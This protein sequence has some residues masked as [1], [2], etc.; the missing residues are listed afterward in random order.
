L[1]KNE[2]DLQ[3]SVNQRVLGSSLRGGATF[4]KAIQEIEWFFVFNTF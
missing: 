3:P 4:D 2:T 1:L